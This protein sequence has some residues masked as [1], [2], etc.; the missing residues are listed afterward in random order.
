MRT[1]TALRSAFT[2]L[3]LLVAT[4]ALA[5]SVSF[6]AA[7]VNIEVPDGWHSSNDGST[8]TVADK[9]EDV[10][11]TF[12]AVD[13]GAVKHAAKVVTH[14]LADKIDQL[15]LSDPQEIDINGMAGVALTGD[16][17]YNG[18]NIDLA[19]I[20]IDTPSDTND[21]VVVAL[22]EDA[23]LARHADE[24]QHIFHHLRPRN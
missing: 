15:T 1:A 14:I 18:A 9:H 12:T 13:A 23:K 4:P 21:L 6:K 7:R 2:G 3:A 16:G 19:I 8:I 24:V 17:F 11:M 10:G 20:V 5:D 22:G